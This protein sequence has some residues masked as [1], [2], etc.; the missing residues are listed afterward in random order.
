EESLVVRL[1][2]IRIVADLGGSLLG[3]ILA[4]RLLARAEAVTVTRRRQAAEGLSHLC[5][6]LARL[7]PSWT[8]TRPKGGLSLWVRLPHGDASELAEV[9]LRHVVSV[10][11]VS[12]AS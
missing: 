2:R 5:A 9:A 6:L 3:Q 7:L 1:A 12:V 4:A 11:P 8:F 10:V